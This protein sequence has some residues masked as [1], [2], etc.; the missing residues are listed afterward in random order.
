M[1]SDLK[2]IPAI[3]SLWTL[4]WPLIIANSA[5]PLL[6][7]ADAAIAGHL[8][9]V[10]YLA[11]VTVG[12]GLFSI[13]FGSFSFLR[14]GTTG[15]VAQA[16]GRADNHESLRILFNAMLLGLFLGIGLTGCSWYLIEPA[17]NL[18]DPADSLIEPLN[19]YLKIRLF[20][21]P[22]TLVTYALTGWFIGRG[23]TKVALYLALGINTLNIALNYILAIRFELNSNGIALGTLIAEY[24]GVI[25]GLMWLLRITENGALLQ[26]AVMK[27]KTLRTLMRVNAPLWMRTIALQSV[28]VSLSIFA[29]RLGPNEAASIGL[30]LILLSAASYALDGL[31]YASEIEAGQ[32]KGQKNFSRFINSLWAGA[33]LTF[34]TALS[35]IALVEFFGP[36]LLGLLTDHKTVIASTSSLLTWFRWVLL[37]LCFSYWL[38]GVFIGL[39]RSWDM[40][41]TMF[42]SVGFGWV[43]ALW[44]IGSQHIDDLF[45]ALLIFAVLRSISLGL[46]LPSVIRDLKTPNHPKL[47][48]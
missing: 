13:F 43:G 24:I 3:R 38:D 36:D 4:A 40:C 34:G 46:R 22:A 25:Y 1:R 33:L 42:L 14:M 23:E 44:I 8:D 39:T 21:A 45:K 48:E 19:Q 20:S 18:A 6:G 31:A 15:L 17:I 41:S 28:F 5:I 26:T 7:L 35:I 27:W 2:L 47:V 32:S 11:S 37:I 30:F 29:A 10:S 16:E 12:A 9:N